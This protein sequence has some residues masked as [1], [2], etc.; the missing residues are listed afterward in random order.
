[1]R[2][3]V[4]QLELQRAFG[5]LLMKVMDMELKTD[6]GHEICPMF[7]FC[8]DCE[9]CFLDRYMETF[10]PICSECGEPI[11]VANSNLN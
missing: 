11:D 6:D 2:K 1:M 7:G 3:L 9:E 5:F 8:P 4:S 10:P